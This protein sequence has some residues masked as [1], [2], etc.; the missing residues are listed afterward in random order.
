MNCPFCI[1]LAVVAVCAVGGGVILLATRITAAGTDLQP[2][3]TRAGDVRRA[4]FPAT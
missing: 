4:C 2:T 3:G 1:A